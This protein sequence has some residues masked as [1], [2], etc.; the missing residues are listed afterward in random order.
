MSASTTAS[1]ILGNIDG[2]E[3]N[4]HTSFLKM[5]TPSNKESELLNDFLLTLQNNYSSSISSTS[6]PTTTSFAD[7]SNV[8]S[9][10]SMT[11]G[12][13]LQNDLKCQRMQREQNENSLSS[14]SS[15]AP[16][17]LSDDQKTCDTKSKEKSP[18]RKRPR[19]NPVWVYFEIRDNIAYC[20][21]DGCK[22]NTGSVYSTNLKVHLKSHHHDKYREVLLAEYRNQMAQQ[23]QQGQ[24]LCLA[25]PAVMGTTLMIPNNIDQTEKK[26]IT[27]RHPTLGSMLQVKKPVVPQITEKPLANSPLL[28]AALKKSTSPCSNDES[29][30]DR[31]KKRK[32]LRRHPVWNF[33]DDLDDKNIGCLQC[34]FKTSSGFTTN[35]KMHLKA[36]HRNDY[37]QVMQM[38]CEQRKEEGCIDSA[39][40]GKKKKRTA[41]ELE[42][43]LEAYKAKHGTELDDLHGNISPQALENI[44]TLLS[45]SNNLKMECDTSTTMDYDDEGVSSPEE[46]QPAEM[47]FE[48]LKA[49]LEDEKPLISE[50]TDK[51]EEDD[52]SLAKFREF[53]ANLTQLS[54][55]NNAAKDLMKQTR[56]VALGRVIKEIGI[57]NISLITSHVFRQ[58]L[59]ALDP[60]YKLPSDMDHLRQLAE[61]SV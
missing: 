59:I 20:M 8:K 18:K 22:Y 37:I 48:S 7:E 30:N 53:M 39:P 43:M 28:A 51:D 35:L 27:E 4:D 42:T 5:L 2:S 19:R 10:L 45:L 46:L 11:L 9:G 24:S 38:E 33:F 15:P 61:N 1:Q 3:E 60:T 16:T 21:E 23:T 31:M 6:I 52:E 50:E 55:D 41:E 57:Q 34:D 56:D 29:F 47:T 58:L 13:A 25:A 14:T 44:A 12:K 26:E 49:Q 54:V 17:E 36:H 40:Q 32:R